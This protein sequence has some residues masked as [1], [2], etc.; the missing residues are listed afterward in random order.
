MALMAL[1][2]GRDAAHVK[3]MSKA[4]QKSA[5]ML[6]RLDCKMLCLGMMESYGLRLMGLF[7]RYMQEVL[8]SA[9][10]LRWR[11]HAS[12]G[13]CRVNERALKNQLQGRKKGAVELVYD[14]A[15]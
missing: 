2:T 6:A 7:V 5:R 11:F 8:H 9:Y 15:Q 14:F 13:Q 10:R 1:A 3:S 12:H 4:C